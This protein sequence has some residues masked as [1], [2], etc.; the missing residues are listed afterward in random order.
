MKKCSR[1][2]EKLTKKNACRSAI[3]SGGYCRP[4]GAQRRKE[5]KDS[6]RPMRQSRK[7]SFENDPWVVIDPNQYNP[8]TSAKV[9]LQRRL[10]RN[11]YFATHPC[12]DCGITD[13]RLLTLDH[14][15]GIKKLNP[16]IMWTTQPWKEIQKEL[17]K[18]EV[19]CH[20]CH[21]IRTSI[22][23]HHGEWVVDIPDELDTQLTLLNR[24]LNHGLA[25]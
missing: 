16:A 7:I 25:A 11:H 20:N 10:Y 5:I 17:K 21:A 4:C 15:R 14:V 8:N 2:K 18:C 24:D 3:Y 6:K 12:M 1:C 9:A 19:V 22:R 13:I 23:K